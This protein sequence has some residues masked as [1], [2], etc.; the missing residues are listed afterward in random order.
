[1]NAPRD[2]L[3]ETLDPPPGG[4]TRL[5]ARLASERRRRVRAG[6]AGAVLAAG[7]AAALAVGVALGP[8]QPAAPWPEFSPLRIR[9]GLAPPPSEPL[10]L[11]PEAQSTVALV[12]V[13]SSTERVALYWVGS[14]A[15]T[16]VAA[17]GAPGDTEPPPRP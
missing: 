4:L 12:R 1:M 10:S 13:P 15:E 14:I 8:A 16:G 11:P 7:G 17:G 9:L 2:N 3:F 6:F 5:R